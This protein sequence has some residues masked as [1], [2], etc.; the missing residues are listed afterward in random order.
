MRPVPSEPLVPSVPI[1]LRR[2]APRSIRINSINSEGPIASRTISSISGNVFAAPIFLLN[3]RISEC[4]TAAS[5]ADTTSWNLL[6]EGPRVD[7]FVPH[8]AFFAGTREWAWE[9]VDAK[10]QSACMDVVGERFHVREALVWH[11]FA[12]FRALSLPAIIDVDVHI[13]T[14]AQSSR[15]DRISGRTD[16]R[17]ANTR[18]EVIPAIPAH[19]RGRRQLGRSRSAG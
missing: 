6:E 4:P 11:Q 2:K 12:G 15:N 19:R 18:S 13:A 14:I 8:A 7:I 1:R 17:I 9:G 10:F 3:D 16:I 5:I